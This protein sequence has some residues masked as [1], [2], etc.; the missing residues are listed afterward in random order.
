[1]YRNDK[2]RNK[3]FEIVFEADTSTG[4]IFNISLLITICLSVLVV[5]M[6]SVPSFSSNYAGL[7]IVLEWIFTIIFCVEYFLRITVTRKPLKYM[8]SFF[9]IIDLLAILPAFL[10]IFFS[11]AHSLLIIRAFRLLRVFRILK[12][13]RY[14]I[15]GQTLARALIASRAKIGVFLFFVVTIVTFLGTVMYLVEGEE[16]G[17]TSIPKS[18]YYTIVTLT[19]VGFGDITPQTTL[20]QFLSGV[21]M[22]LGYAIIAVPT[23]I[24]SVEIAKSSV[25]TQVCPACLRTG[26]DDDATY[27]KYCGAEINPD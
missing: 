10:V 19:T 16:N 7:L 8:F 3:L 13:T 25:N 20:G 2:I 4:K 6:E 11:G 23:G 21:V 22:I 18:I 14:S 1:M 15:A 26:H 24:I 5:I 12:L 9:G 27:C 17:F